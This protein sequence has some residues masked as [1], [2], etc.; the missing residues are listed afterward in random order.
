MTVKIVL[1]K[2]LDKKLGLGTRVLTDSGHE[3]DNITSISVSITPR[4]IITATIVVAVS[5]IE[6]LEGIEA[7]VN[8]INTGDD[9]E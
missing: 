5:E 1:P 9:N 7:F 2:G 8:V 3:I 4:D 6:N